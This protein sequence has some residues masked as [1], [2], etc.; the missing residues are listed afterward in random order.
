INF[1]EGEPNDFASMYEVVYRRYKRVLEEGLEQPDLILIDGGKGQLS[2]ALKALNDLN[3]PYKGIIGLAKR[4]EE[5]FLPGEKVS[6]I[7]KQNSF[8]LKLIQHVRDEA[9]RFAITFHRQ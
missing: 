4:E 9:H 7:L 1:S 8:A 5:V 2:S 3:Y 6:V